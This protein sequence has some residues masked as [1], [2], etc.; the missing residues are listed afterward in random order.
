MP[1]QRRVL[2]GRINSR[3]QQ[4]LGHRDFREEIN[5]LVESRATEQQQDDRVWIASDLQWDATE[6]FVIG[7]LG[8]RERR[9]LVNFNRDAWSFLK[10]EREE[11]DLPATRDLVPFA[12]DARPERRW[13]AH[14][15]SNRIR[16][17]TFALGLEMALNAAREH[18]GLPT[19]WEVDT[20]TSKRTLEHW[21]RQYGQYVTQLYRVVK[22]PNPVRDVSADQEEMAALA[23]RRKEETYKAGASNI[24][25]TEPDGQLTEAAQ[26][27]FD[28]M[29]LGY[30][31]LKV[32]AAG[33]GFTET[34]STKRSIDD[35]RIDDFD[36]DLEV[37]MSLVL[38]RLRAYSEE[39][40][41]AFNGANGDV[42]ETESGSSD[43]EEG[44]GEDGT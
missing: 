44:A 31:E 37:G 19:D 4:S 39:R 25:L 11:T 28:G 10:G 38:D 2:Y 12:I 22:M 17:N 30:V 27:K 9:E 26:R 42:G 1:R 29:D 21:I 8:F 16:Q 13:V 36:T 23:A 32:T 14:A 43:T 35:T 6:T 18:L 34:F 33:P 15:T 3:P 40:A 24:R 20:V 7:L 41:T 5:D